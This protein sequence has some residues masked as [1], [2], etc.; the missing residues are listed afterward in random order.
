MPDDADVLKAKGDCFREQGRWVEAID[1]FRRACELDPRN[2][3]LWV[4]LAECH[5]WTRRY[6]EADKECD[7]ALAFA[8]D[9]MWS[10][11]TKVFNAWSWKGASGATRTTLEAM[12]AEIRDEWVDWAWFRQGL[13]EGK[14]QEALDRI[15][16]KSDGWIRVKISAEPVPMLSAQIYELMGDKQRALAAYETARKMLE[17]EVQAHPDDPRYHS[18]LGVTYAALGRRDEAIREGKRAVELLPV[19]KDAV[20]GLPGVIDLAHIY[21]LVG[22]HRA[23]LEQLELP[24]LGPLVDINGMARDGSALEPAPGRSRIPAI[25][26]KIRGGVGAIGSV[27]LFPLATAA[28]LA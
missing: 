17:A 14:Y 7:K 10:Y 13:I 15:A 28:L 21:T 24:A 18:S 6:P 9:Q 16:A 27:A 8:P 25:A 20:Y 11:L 4:E 22:D 26:R 5:W 19:T 3:S 1:H 12:P 2:G 23:A